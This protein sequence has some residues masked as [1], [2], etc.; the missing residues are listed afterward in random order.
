MVHT[1]AAQL[2]STVAVP[3]GLL[4]YPSASFWLVTLLFGGGIALLLACLWSERGH[5]NTGGTGSAAP[6]HQPSRHAG[7]PTSGMTGATVGF[8]SV[9]GRTMP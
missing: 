3:I 8:G 7:Q 2:W 9:G 4:W 1:L 5:R 6:S